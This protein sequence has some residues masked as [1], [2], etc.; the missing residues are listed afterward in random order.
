MCSKFKIRYPVWKLEQQVELLSH[1]SRAP[2]L[3]LSGVCVEFC[4]FQNIQ[5]ER[6]CYIPCRCFWDRLR[7]PEQDE[8]VTEDEGMNIL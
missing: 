1:S 4:I 2:R 3:I 8:M 7:G 5:I 6:I